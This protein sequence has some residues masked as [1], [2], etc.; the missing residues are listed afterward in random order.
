M[1]KELSRVSIEEALKRIYQEIAKFEPVK[2]STPDALGMIVADDVV[3]GKDYP[4]YSQAE[5]DG[6]ALSSKLLSKASPENTIR[7]KVLG[8][9]SP[10]QI[11]SELERRDC[12]FRVL[13]GAYLPEWC[14]AVVMQEDVELEDG[15]AIFTHPVQRGA[16]IYAK[17]SDIHKGDIILRKGHMI[18]SFDVSLLLSYGLYE[19]KVAPKLKVAL[20][21]TGS[22]LVD[23]LDMIKKGKIL[24]TNKIAISGILSGFGFSV[25]DAGLATDDDREIASAISKA[26]EEVNVVITTGGSS[27]GEKDLVL[28]SFKRLEGKIILHGL[29]LRPSSTAG[30]ATIRGKL[31]FALSGLIQSCVVA[32]FNLVLPVLRYMQGI[33]G[34]EVPAVM[35]RLDKKV[36]ASWPK[37]F[38][39]I[40]WLRLYSK[41]ASLYAAPSLVSS[42]SKSVITHSDG[43]A[44][45]DGNTV[46]AKGSVIRV[47]LIKNYGIA[48][49]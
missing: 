18:N 48:D 28:D 34:Y 13:T 10:G 40:I 24:E 49:M 17:G 35:A 19:V 26:L 5:K 1:S 15:E 27:V 43:Y 39:R 36:V 6:F 22:E 16:N 37:D 14:D 23:S 46:L 21:A 44:V 31:I 7:L 9:L 32:M 3:A 33:E 8:T 45:I 4:P 38:K 29:K 12:C 41:Q 11:P 25:I 42:H 30:V 2:V 20:L 47:F